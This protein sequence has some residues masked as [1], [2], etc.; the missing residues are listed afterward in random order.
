MYYN[1]K[2]EN[3]FIVTKPLVI[4]SYDSE[5]SNLFKGEKINC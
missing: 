4:N 1:Q 3:N 2:D 5:S